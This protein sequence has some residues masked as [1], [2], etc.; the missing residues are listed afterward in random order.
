MNGNDEITCVIIFVSG[1]TTQQLPSLRTMNRKIDQIV[2][3]SMQTHRI[4][5]HHTHI[6]RRRFIRRAFAPTPPNPAIGMHIPI[7]SRS[8][9]GLPALTRGQVFST[10]RNSR[11]NP[12]NQVIFVFVPH[13]NHPHILA[14]Q[15][16]RHNRGERGIAHVRLPSHFRFIPTPLF[17]RVKSAAKL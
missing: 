3:E 11:Q 16:A 6:P 1:T 4:L 9:V 17:S 5:H 14:A 2:N 8:T 10:A 7:Q 13:S 15:F 12:L